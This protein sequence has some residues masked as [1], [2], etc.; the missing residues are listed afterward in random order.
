M[1]AT[2]CRS[3]P[4]CVQPGKQSTGASCAS[5]MPCMGHCCRA[6]PCTV[7]LFAARLP[8]TGGGHLRGK[9]GRGGQSGIIPSPCS[10]SC[11]AMNCLPGPCLP[12]ALP[13]TVTLRALKGCRQRGRGDIFLQLAAARRRGLVP[14]LWALLG[15]YHRGGGGVTLRQLGLQCSAKHA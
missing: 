1:C 2:A 7:P 5:Q 14:G 8:Y 11:L 3:A 10:R 6:I 12:L 9:G 4:P 13:L 15:T